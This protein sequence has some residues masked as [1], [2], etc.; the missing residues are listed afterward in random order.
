MNF[1][2]FEKMNTHT[3]K[4]IIKSLEQIIEEREA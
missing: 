4:M 1:D 3:L 2:E